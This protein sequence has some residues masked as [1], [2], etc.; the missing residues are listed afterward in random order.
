MP[1]VAG[2]HFSSWAVG[3]IFGITLYGLAAVAV[4][5]AMYSLAVLGRRPPTWALAAL[6]RQRRCA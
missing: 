2:P 1:F 4:L 6:R 3:L 5:L